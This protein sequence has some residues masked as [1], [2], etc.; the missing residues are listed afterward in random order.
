M[1]EP[2]HPKMSRAFIRF[3]KSRIKDDLKKQ[4]RN[5]LALY[6]AVVTLDKSVRKC[7]N[8]MPKL[9]FSTRKHLISKLEVQ[10]FSDLR[11]TIKQASGDY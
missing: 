8:E 2:V 4:K 9:G 1:C 3:C 11:D 5:E 6:K 10:H 7:S